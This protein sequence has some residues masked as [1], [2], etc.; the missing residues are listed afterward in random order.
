MAIN[1]TTLQDE[2]GSYSDWIELYNSGTNAVDLGG[3]YLA[4]SPSNLTHWQFP[5]TNLGPNRFLVVFASNKNRRIAGAPLHTNFKLGG[6]GEYLALVMPDGMTKASEFAPVF[7]QQYADVS[8]GYAMTGKVTTLLASNASVR[9]LVPS[10][11]IGTSWRQFGFDDSSWR[12]GLLGAGYDTS[13]SYAP[14]I[15]LD[16]KSTMLNVNASAYI[17]SVFN[18]AGPAAFNLLTLSLRYDD[19]F[20]AYLNGTEVLRRNAPVTTAWNSSATERH[21]APNPGAL[22]ENFEGSATNY[23]LSQYGASPP[24]SVQ[25]A[26]VYTT[27]K[28]LRLLYDGTNA[29]ANAVTFNQTA[30]G[31]FQ[32]IVADFDFRITDAAN[33]PAD[34]FAFLLVPTSLYGTNGPGLNTSSQAA[35]EP[36][37]RG[38]FGIGFDV[39]PHASHNDVS[40]HW[41]GT[42]RINI[43]IPASTIDLA[44]GVF[45]HAKVTLQYVAGGASVTVTLTRDINRTPGAPFSPIANFFI[46]GLNPFDCRV[47]FGGRS[48]G[49]NL[50]LDLDNC[51]MQFIPPAGPIA[52]EDFD[53]DPSLLV[54][55]PNV[56]AIQGLNFSAGSSNFLIQP[57]LL[58]RELVLK[59]PATYLYPATPGAWNNSA[60]SLLAPPPVSFLPAAGVYTS[61]TLTVT[62]AAA[63]SAATIRY[64]LDGSMPGVNSP[65]YTNAFLLSTNAL[66]RARS[67]VGGIPG[68][69]AAADYTLLDSS[70]TNFSSNLPLIIIDTAGQTIPD[71]SK[72]TSFALFIDTNAVTGRTSLSGS[73]NYKGGLGIGLH[74]S[75]SL[76]FPKK[77]YA[78]ELD[79]DIGRAVDFNLL[80]LPAGSDWLLY[81]SCDDK[82]FMNNVLTEEIF[83]SMGHYAVRRK[84]TELFLHT[85][86]GKLTAA[87]YQG[88]YVVMERI[89]V[90][91]NRVNIAKLD[92]TDNVPPAVTG[93]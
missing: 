41:D 70:L 10:A 37:Y 73:S 52:F 23:T 6:S 76:M 21:G 4:N 35:E 58:A 51:N 69:V 57:Q 16:L 32:T 63:D 20:I 27:G 24:P 85:G 42:E 15:G 81:R 28:F 5:S 40:A 50:G 77:T 47:E 89:R 88:I 65:I 38:V 80:G 62:L 2:D 56:L 68:E 87:D 92:P 74:G 3:W 33:N 13:G 67:E 8:Y 82:T 53:L 75:S 91:Q 12:A 31:L 78:I 79:D 29:S 18:V 26:G 71:G 64:T 1:N 11:D 84:Y 48:G 7:P 34:G 54:P 14:A 22:A 46:A 72:I 19:G 43:T 61:N 60:G 36:N 25:P 90:A 59:E 9:A 45:H 93:G 86:P 66:I 83:E 39:Y 17:R 44:A 30:P 55:G 49:L